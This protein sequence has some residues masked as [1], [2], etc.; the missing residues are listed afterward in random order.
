MDLMQMWAEEQEHSGFHFTKLLDKET[1]VHDVGFHERISFDEMAKLI[2]AALKQ[3]MPDQL[4]V[5]VTE[6]SGGQTLLVRI[7]QVSMFGTEVP[8]DIVLVKQLMSEAMLLKRNVAVLEQEKADMMQEMAALKKNGEEVVGKLEETVRGLEEE[9]VECKAKSKA[10]K[11]RRDLTIAALKKE[12]ETL[13]AKIAAYEGVEDEKKEDG[14]GSGSEVAMQSKLVWKQT[15]AGHSDDIYSVSMSVDGRVAVS[16]SDDKSIRVWDVEKGECLS[17][18]EGAHSF[19][20]TCVLLTS[21]QT[22]VIS[23]DWDGSIKSWSFDGREL[24]L[25]WEEKFSGKLWRMCLNDDET[26]IAAVC[27]DNKHCLVYNRVDAN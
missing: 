3:E 19:D 20:V 14:G 11:A 10:S 7:K 6:Q 16:G 9:L 24:K 5:E 25:I 13:I 15:W 8:Y 18:T 12:N 17:V 4:K 22:N 2:E 23:C 27:R 1:L 21:D 26:M